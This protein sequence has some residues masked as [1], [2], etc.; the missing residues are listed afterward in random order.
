MSAVILFPS[1]S[2][3][4]VIAISS[5]PNLKDIFHL[6]VSAERKSHD[7]QTKASMQLDIKHQKWIKH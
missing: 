1:L 4:R 3:K 2:R 5:Y 7:T 6:F